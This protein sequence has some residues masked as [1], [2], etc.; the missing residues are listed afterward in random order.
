MSIKSKWSNVA[1]KA[2]I[3]LIF[4]LNKTPNFPWIRQPPGTGV[5]LPHYLCSSWTGQSCMNYG[6]AWAN[7]LP[8]RGRAPLSLLFFWTGQSCLWMLQCLSSSAHSPHGGAPLACLPVLAMLQALPCWINLWYPLHA[9]S[10]T[11]QFWLNLA[12][13]RVAR[14]A[15]QCL[16]GWPENMDGAPTC[17]PHSRDM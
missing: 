15:L 5:A 7:T 13:G 17:Y 11:L 2:I 6:N 16:V 8:R 3:S 12:P 10:S 14:N 4:C 1:L 9:C